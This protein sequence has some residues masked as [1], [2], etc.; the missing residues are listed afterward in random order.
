MVLIDAQS[1]ARFGGRCSPTSPETRRVLRAGVDGTR[2]LARLL[3][4]PLG[5]IQNLPRGDKQAYNAYAV[6]S[7]SAQTVLDEVMGMSEGAAQARAVTT[8][9]ALPLIVLS[10]GKD[11]DAESA[12]RRLATS[13][14]RR[15]ASTSSQK[16]AA[17]A[18]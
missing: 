1:A 12:P 3:A 13:S 14:Y 2:R 10:R 5:S 4:G 6:T 17:I 9:G 15:S 11:M 18:S 16:T 8:L 7:R